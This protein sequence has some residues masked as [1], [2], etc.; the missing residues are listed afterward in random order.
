MNS[1]LLSSMRSITNGAAIILT[2]VCVIVTTSGCST[3]PGTYGGDTPVSSASGG[4]ASSGSAQ[5]SS[6][7]SNGSK[8]N[9]KADAEKYYAENPGVEGGWSKAAE[10]VVEEKLGWNS[11]PNGTKTTDLP[12]DLNGVTFLGDDGTEVS[13]LADSKATIL[14][15]QDQAPIEASYSIGEP[16]ATEAF[17]LKYSDAG[18]GKE[19]HVQYAAQCLGRK[20]MLNVQ[21]STVP[22]LPSVLRG[23]LPQ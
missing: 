19:C 16:G 15:P 11:L 5:S 2:L 7:P 23:T 1:K 8:F 12:K 14:T 20:V 22:K 13:C 18:S 9:V 21:R 6:A 10:I 4:A 17:D 3:A